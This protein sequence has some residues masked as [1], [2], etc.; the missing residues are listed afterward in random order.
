MV[1]NNPTRARLILPT[2][3]S[4]VSRGK[5]R[6]AQGEEP[7]TI[8]EFG[9]VSASAAKRAWARLIKQV[10][11]ADPL[12]CPQCA[13]PMRIIAF[14]EQPEVIEKIL[15]HLGIWPAHVHSPPAGVPVVLSPA[16]GLMAA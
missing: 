4:N 6:K 9:E 2:S 13:G 10:Y 11:E 14:I 15:T 3:Y 7:A 5:R 1:C 12:I 16:T 8:A